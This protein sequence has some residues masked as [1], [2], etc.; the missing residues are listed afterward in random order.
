MTIKHLCIYSTLGHNIQYISIDETLT[1]TRVEHFNAKFFEVEH[2]LNVFKI[3]HGIIDLRPFNSDTSASCGAYMVL[4]TSLQAI[5]DQLC[6]LCMKLGISV[7]AHSDRMWW[8]HHS[9]GYTH[10][11]SAWHSRS[12]HKSSLVTNKFRGELV[13][14]HFFVWSWE[15]NAT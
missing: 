4:S 13:P 7:I 5:L 14:K 1:Y 6:I 11:S 2:V 15:Y 12:N 8:G 9:F 3:K 10:W